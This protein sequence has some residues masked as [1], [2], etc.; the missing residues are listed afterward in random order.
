VTAVALMKRAALRGAGTPP[1]DAVLRGVSGR[2]GALVL[3]YHRFRTPQRPPVPSDPDA[4]AADALDAQMRHLRRHF[5]VVGPEDLP[6]ALAGRR[7][8]VVVVTVDDG[9]R[10]GYEIAFPVFA[11]HGVP[12]T[13]FVATGFPDG[14]ARAWWEELRRIVE[15]AAVPSLPRSRWLPEA[16][17]L[18][19][20][21]RE[22]AIRLLQRIYAR[23][24][25][26]ETAAFLEHVGRAAGTGRLPADPGGTWMTWDEIR[27]LRR[28]GMRI[29]GHTA[30][31][32]VLS[33]L[34]P[35]AQRDEVARCRARLEE[36]VGVPMRWFAYPVGARDT[37]DRHT[38]A[39]L[40]DHGVEFAFSCYGGWASPGVDVDPYDVPRAT[41]GAG[42]DLPGFRRLTGLP[43]AF[44]RW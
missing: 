18:R 40:R 34:A 3:A 20:P 23:L 24:P 42:L 28:G 11:A 19:G 1:G 27:E 12:A 10:D 32:P 21:A 26:G 16:L 9:Y 6:A 39:A 35:G 30:H 8:R 25:S 36:E 38:G 5:D 4:V 2:R 7:E 41:V 29:G 22:P 37:F 14:E 44:A 33:R 17:P 31:H 43:A 15:R 13:F